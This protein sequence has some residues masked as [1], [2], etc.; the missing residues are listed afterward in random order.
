MT[1]EEMLLQAD[2]DGELS[3]AE[4]AGLGQEVPDRAER[5]AEL[6]ALSA[7]V[8]RELSYHAAPATLRSALRLQFTRA[9]PAARR[10]GFLQARM[11][12]PFG[13]GFALAAS[14][15]LMLPAPSGTGLPDQIV[16][17]HIRALQPGHLMDVAS[18]DQHTVKPWFDGRLDFAPPVVDLRAKG[19]PLTGGRLDYLAGRPVAVLVYERRQH[20][21]N[22][23]IWPERAGPL[24][25]SRSGYNLMRWQ[26]D[27]MTFWAVSD[28]NR[29]E[30]AEF[31]AALHHG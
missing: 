10:P 25:T 19:Y 4:A 2:A 29:D 22:V 16:S 27:G 26:Q 8:R 31:A 1:R 12:L 20:I 11:A 5:A 7:R 18:T 15:L 21:I 9:R 3:P 6:S 17:D 30:L 13:A 28:L 24:T 23:F 14:L